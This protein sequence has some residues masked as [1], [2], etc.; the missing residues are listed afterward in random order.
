MSGAENS[1]R[2]SKPRRTN[3]VL[4]DTKPII[5]L[6]AKED[7]WE[8]VKKILSAIEQEEIV[9]AISVISLTEI[10]YKYLR[11]KRADLA[12]ERSNT[13][14]YATYLTKIEVDDQVAIKAGEF[15]GKYT[16]S[17]ADAMIASA[18]RTSDSLIISDDPDFRKIGEV[19]TLS[20]GQYVAKHLRS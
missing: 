2:E 14:R 9:G 19:E 20:E 13:L 11:E 6:F 4:L 16:V 10:Y 17:V 12:E 3:R 7:G 1:T 18:A 15:K 5:K 8:D